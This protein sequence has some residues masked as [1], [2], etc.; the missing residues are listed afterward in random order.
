VNLIVTGRENSSAQV[1]QF[2]KRG[3]SVETIPGARLPDILKQNL[4]PGLIADAIVCF[5]DAGAQE[6]ESPTLH[7]LRMAEAQRVA[8]EIRRLPEFCAMEDGRKW[9]A[10][11]VLIVLSG[12]E[13]V[14]VADELRLLASSEAIVFVEALDNFD[15]TFRA[16]DQSVRAY[17]QRILDEFS[18]LGFLVTYK[19]GLYR[20]G[21]AMS[22]TGDL[23]GHFYY[24][25]KDQRDTRAQFFT[26]D[27]DLY[28]IQDEVEQFEA[29]INN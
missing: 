7:T 29:L 6:W 27:R 15:A 8:L 14:L 13:V 22:P 12:D 24:G 26:V 20:V 28:G 1:D 16:V 25:P 4:N 18:N 10:V 9:R 17:R 5:V 21:P 19:N 23:E 2:R 11:P 3:C